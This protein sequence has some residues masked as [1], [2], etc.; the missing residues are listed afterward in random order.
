M[1]VK[2]EQPNTAACLARLKARPSF[3]RVIE[4]A[5]PWWKLFPEEPGVGWRPSEQ[6]PEDT[7]LVGSWPV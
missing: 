1:L 4:E 3:A 5:K 2:G 6:G 7:F